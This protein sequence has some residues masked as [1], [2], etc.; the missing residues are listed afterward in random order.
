MHYAARWGRLAI[1]KRLLEGGADPTL[2]DKDGNTA[3]D[4]AREQGNIEVVVLL[5][6]A[7]NEDRPMLDCEAI[8]SEGG[9]APSWAHADH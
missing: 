2:R 1:A 5:Q 6:Y 8:R 4:V 7:A 9:E 3:L